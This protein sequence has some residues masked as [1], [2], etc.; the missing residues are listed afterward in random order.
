[1]TLPSIVQTLCVRVCARGRPH[2]NETWKLIPSIKRTT[3]TRIHARTHKCAGVHAHPHI[4]ERGKEKN[5]S[6][7]TVIHISLDKMT[8][9]GLIKGGLYQIASALGY[10]PPPPASVSTHVPTDTGQSAFEGAPSTGHRHLLP[11]ECLS[12][13]PPPSTSD[14]SPARTSA[15]ATAPTQPYAA[16]ATSLHTASTFAEFNN[17][18][19]A[20]AAE[21]GT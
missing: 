17:T 7:Y 4:N 16:T 1:M 21:A 10:T 5:K 14:P 18:I 8:T 20:R 11:E 13:L 19:E 3:R 9:S 12:S 2:G 6:A 15:A